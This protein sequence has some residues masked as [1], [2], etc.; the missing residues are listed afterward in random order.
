MQCARVLIVDDEEGIRETLRAVLEDE[1]FLV[2]AEENGQDAIAKSK[3]KFHNLALVDVHLPDTDDDIV[4]ILGENH[5]EDG[6][7]KCTSSISRYYGLAR[8]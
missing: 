7:L 2:G 1:R 3:A 5:S 4:D 6:Q 8:K